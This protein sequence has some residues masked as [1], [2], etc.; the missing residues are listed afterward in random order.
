MNMDKN[1]VRYWRTLFF[2]YN[3]LVLRKCENWKQLS[4]SHTVLSSD[5]EKACKLILY[6]CLPDKECRGCGISS[7]LESF[8]PTKLLREWFIAV[9]DGEGSR[10]GKANPCISKQWCSL[11]N[12]K[13]AQS[14]FRPTF[15]HSFI[16]SFSTRGVHVLMS[17]NLFKKTTHHRK[18]KMQSFL[19]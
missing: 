17:P 14:L 1:S 18:L 6:F 13:I 12:P 7:Y 8:V 15:I 16:H 11:C 10:Y 3:T 4:H 9:T 2:G 19:N 5:L